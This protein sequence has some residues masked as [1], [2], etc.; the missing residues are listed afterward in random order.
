MNARAFLLF[1]S[2]TVTWFCVF[3][4]GTAF[5]QNAQSVGDTKQLQ[6]DI[7]SLHQ[8]ALQ[9]DA[10]AEYKLGWSYMTGT[11]IPQNYSEAAKYLR[12]AAEQ[13]FPDAE[14][15][16]GYL[17]E[18]GKGVQRDYHQAIVY[19]TTAARQGHSTAENNLGSMYEYGR[20]VRKNLRQAENW[21]RMGAEH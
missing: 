2:L 19:Y 18:Q 14:F 20:G 13:G 3:A 1:T 7:S 12:Q 15:A 8:K 10:K 9:G 11:G 16:L 4:S 5:E 21:Y 6:L 17:Y